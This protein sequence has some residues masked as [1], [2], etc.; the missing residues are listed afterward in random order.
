MTTCNTECPFDLWKEHQWKKKTLDSSFCH[1]HWAA[2]S[3]SALPDCFNRSHEDQSDKRNN[4]SSMDYF[5]IIFIYNL[6]FILFSPVGSWRGA[7]S[8]QGGRQE[9]TSVISCKISDLRKYLRLI[10][11]KR[12]PD[13][14]GIGV[15]KSGTT[16]LGRTGA[17]DIDKLM[18]WSDLGMWGHFYYW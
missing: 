14:I 9:K 2:E 7:Q 11:R 18:L 5:H 12:L 15:K 4:E 8:Q 3:T 6:L 10:F 13:I 17:G 16:T 1:M